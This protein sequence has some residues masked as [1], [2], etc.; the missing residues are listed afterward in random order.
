MVAEINIFRRVFLLFCFCVVTAHARVYTVFTESNYYPF[1]ALEDGVH[2]GF[3]VEVLRAIASAENLELKF[4]TDLWE[5]LFL[6]VQ[7]S[8]A[9]I[10]A[11]AISITED[12]KELVDFSAPYFES[13]LIFLVHDENN[14]ETITDLRDKKVGVLKASNP[15]QVLRTLNFSD[16]KIYQ[17]DF[18]MIR[19]VLKGEII[20]TLND[21]GFIDYY[22]MRFKDDYPIQRVPLNEEIDYYGF[23]VKKGNEELVQILNRGLNTI[24]ENGTYDL[25]YE[26]YFSK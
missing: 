2:T 9:D 10:I 11:T 6:R 22:Y 23:A 1:V 15:E 14:I 21:S 17:K 3:D 25:I 19:D 24:K 16:L 20:A 26:K 7:N 12:R 18:D 13:K 4:E 5:N 8:S